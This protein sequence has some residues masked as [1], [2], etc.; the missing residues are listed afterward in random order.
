[1]YNDREKPLSLDDLISV[2]HYSAVFPDKS[3]KLDELGRIRSETSVH[4]LDKNII[5]T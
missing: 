5:I 1:M 4:D 3:I 2:S